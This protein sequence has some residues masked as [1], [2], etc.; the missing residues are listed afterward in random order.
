MKEFLISFKKFVWFVTKALFIVILVSSLI[1]I[2]PL[3]PYFLF[4][5]LQINCSYGPLI[6][7]WGVFLVIVGQVYED[8]GDD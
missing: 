3:L 8:F 6:F 4:S 2:P 1:F 7:I 5:F